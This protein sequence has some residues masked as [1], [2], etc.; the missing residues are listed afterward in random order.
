[1][2]WSVPL[3]LAALRGLLAQGVFLAF[4]PVS[5]VPGARLGGEQELWAEILPAGSRGRCLFSRRE[6]AA[7]KQDLPQAACCC[8]LHSGENHRFHNATIEAEGSLCWLQSPRPVDLPCQALLGSTWLPAPDPDQAGSNNSCSAA[9][10]YFSLICHFFFCLKK[11]KEKTK[12]N[13]LWGHH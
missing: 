9:L 2:S 4:G 11:T 8:L 3:E 13:R 5:R 6:A 1:M 7:R 10:V 12:Q